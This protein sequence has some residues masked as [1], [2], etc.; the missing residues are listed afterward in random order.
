MDGRQITPSH[1]LMK[2]LKREEV[3]GRRYNSKIDE[4]CAEPV[5]S[6]NPL[7]QAAHR[8]PTE[9]NKKLFTPADIIINLRNEEKNLQSNL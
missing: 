5:N 1:K 7:I 2:L 9:A 6:T 8:I 3:I 4:N